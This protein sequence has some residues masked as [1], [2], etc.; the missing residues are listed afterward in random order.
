MTQRPVGTLTIQIHTVMQKLIEVLLQ[1]Q[2]YG[3]IIL[4][5]QN[6]DII[7]ICWGFFFSLTLMHVKLQFELSSLEISRQLLV[8]KVNHPAW[9]VHCC[10]LHPNRVLPPR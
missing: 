8:S 6:S 9:N 10:L 1:H 5:I 4:M 3:L 2:C 7:F